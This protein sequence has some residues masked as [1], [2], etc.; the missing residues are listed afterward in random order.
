MLDR[1]AVTMPDWRERNP[2]DLGV[3]LVELLAYAGD[4]L[5][6]F[7]D[8][9][10][11]EAYLGTARRRTSRAPARAPGR[12]PRCTTAP[13]RAPGWSS[14]P[15][16]IAAPPRR[17]ALPAG[18]RVTDEPGDARTPPATSSFE[19]LHAVTAL[20]RVAATRS[21]STP[22]ATS[23]AA[24][25]RARRGDAR[26][27]HRRSRAARAATCSCSKRCA[28]AETRP[29]PRTPTRRTATPCA[30][31]TNPR[32]RIDPLHAAHR[33]CEIRW[34]DEDALP[35]PLCL[36]RVR[37]RRGR[38]RAVAVARG[39]VVLADHG[40]TILDDRA[41]GG[42]WCRATCLPTDA[43]GRCSTTPALTQAVR[44]RRS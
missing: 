22:G 18:T 44:L 13:T 26:R 10:A 42:D 7:Q 36:A 37:R 35:F 19:T 9:V 28:G 2:A 39:N 4:Q 8:A 40:L 29:C 31:R 43:T 21:A 41:A 17:P 23:T 14:R 3:T 20:T 24:C 27:E 1:L 32:D 38:D 33:C 25:R 30:S 11:T 6:Y 34:H 15:T 16:P 5:S 12:L